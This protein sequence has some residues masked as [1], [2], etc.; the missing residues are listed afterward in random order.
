MKL[1]YIALLLSILILSCT[2]NTDDK[3]ISEFEFAQVPDNAK[4]WVYYW[5][6]K[7][8]VSKELIT[9]DLTEMK[10][11]GV[12]GI[13]LF[14]SR[15]YHD[16][17]YTGNIPVPLEIKYEFMS[18][19][20]R[21]MVKYTLEEAN[22]LGL[23]VSINLAD[24]GGT[25]SGPWD[26]KE[27]GPKQLLWSATTINGPQV[28]S[29]PLQ[30]PQDKQFF[31]DII[32][33][34]TKISKSGNSG[35]LNSSWQTVTP[36]ANIPGEGQPVNLTENVKNNSLEW[37]VPE[38]T[39]RILRFGY[40]VIGT[41]GS[42]D[43]LSK[44]IV[45]H[46][47][48]LMGAQLL[49]DA[50][51]LARTTLTHFYNVSW[52]GGLPDWTVGFEKEFKKYR[53]YELFEYMPALAGITVKDSIKTLQFLRDYWRTVSDCFKVNC[54]ETIGELC[55]SNG[56]EWHSENGGPWTRN[57]PMFKEA[58]MLEFWG[59]NDMPQG[60]F[61]CASPINPPRSNVRFTAMAAHTYNNALVAVEAFT[62]M[63]YHWTLYLEE[64]KRLADFNFVDGANFFIWHTFTASPE[65]LGKPGFE[66]FAG[67]HINTN[68]TWWNKS[69]DFFDYLG[70]CQYMLRQ[71]LFSADVCCYVSDKNYVTWGRGEKWHKNQT[72][73]LPSGYTYDLINAEILDR[74]SVK[75]SKLVL[76]NGMSYKLLVIDL[77]EP[78]MP[79]K[80]LMKIKELANNG[81]TIVLG[82]KKPQRTPGIDM[83]NNLSL[84]VG[85]LW[86][87]AG[88]NNHGKG[89]VYNEVPLDI[90]LDNLK[91]KPDF[92][93]PF[94]YIHRNSSGQDIYFVSGKGASECIFRVTG[95]KPEIWN[96]L[97]GETMEALV[98]NH[99]DDGRTSVSLDLPENGSVF[100]VFKEKAPSK[101][102]ISA[103][104]SGKIKSYKHNGNSTIVTAERGSYKFNNS[105]N[106]LSEFEVKGL[107]LILEGQWEVTFKPEGQPTIA[108]TFDNLTLWNE[109][110]DPAIKFFSGS[111]DYI[112]SFDIQKAMVGKPAWLKLGKVH[113]VCKVWVNG[114]DLGVVWTSPWET[115]L[116]EVLKEG[117]NNIRIEVTNCWANRL[118][119]DAG[120]PENER[121]T[122]TNV[123]LVPDRSV[124]KRP[125]QAFSADDKLMSSGLIGPISIEFGDSFEINR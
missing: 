95:K 42:V 67:T 121:T 3:S 22:R 49:K 105:S 30:K 14:D 99:T 96:P 61:W 82:S 78:I 19:E 72:L 112:K 107:P 71:G 24:S 39:W 103:T 57:A 75:D 60:E 114:K 85:E 8:N 32:V 89:V 11:K 81:A 70:R 21:E 106:N 87:K 35:D 47:F 55:H 101:H 63:S 83:S 90:V 23:K 36:F 100:V 62:H 28:I 15:N 1:R 44:E 123:R 27:N 48:N 92:K 34:A 46:Y 29:I 120:L 122:K 65:E 117:I 51:E 17:Y 50:G 43:I 88:I 18:P 45:T 110:P 124:Y 7:G 52:E 54:Y 109:N 5:W 102:F 77:E 10:D 59:R 118:I 13:L 26:L 73:T 68:V 4:P 16:D 37:T 58:D 125:F 74:I 113:D 115:D 79:E 25:L 91:L 41:K 20:W 104:G 108:K 116:T 6:L 31:Q 111:A 76:P 64:L 69:G 12:G 119:G 84:L 80:A 2:V 56:I 9:R 98:W 53:D 97:T 38:G 94:E 66:Y 33:M 40:H 93:G 86:G